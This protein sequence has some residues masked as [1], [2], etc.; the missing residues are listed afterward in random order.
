MRRFLD[1]RA[2]RAAGRAR[3]TVLLSKRIGIVFAERTWRV[4]LV[5][6]TPPMRACVERSQES[7]EAGGD[8]RLR[9]LRSARE[10][11]HSEAAAADA[12]LDEQPSQEV[13]SGPGKGLRKSTTDE[14]HS[15]G[16]AAARR[17]HQRWR[18]ESETYS[19]RSAARARSA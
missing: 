6:R 14:E 3:D 8:G 18:T 19:Y 17:S 4:V 10:A 2:E 16:L 12:V 1:A 11:S 7:G 15:D 9:S 5:Q 13:N